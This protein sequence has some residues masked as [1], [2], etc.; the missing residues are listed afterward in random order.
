MAPADDLDDYTIMAISSLSPG[1]SPRL[2][3]EDPE[4]TR[5]L[6]ESDAEL[7]P[8][9]V[10][11]PTLRV[12]DG[13]HRLRAALLRGEEKIK[14]RFF[15]GDEEAAFV[16]AVESNIAHGL[17]LSLADR[18][19]AAARILS[20]HP[21]WSDRAIAAVTGL[22]AKTVDTIRRTA[23]AGIPQL[24]SRVGRDGRVRPLNSADGRRRACELF[25]LCPDAS[26]RKVAEQAGISLGTARDVRQRM[27]RGEDPIPAQQ[28]ARDERREQAPAEH[29]LRRVAAAGRVGGPK[30]P[31]TILHQ[32]QR[33]PSVRF[34]DSGRTLLRWLNE[35][36]TGVRGW[37][38]LSGTMPS[39]CAYMIADLACAMAEE[40][41]EFA[42]HVRHRAETTA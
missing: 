38:S 32:L 14:V 9:L 12:I 21:Q 13:M 35:H 4:H 24:H 30:D 11:R 20:S 15:D 42:E 26:L 41:L 1:E 16:T 25:T 6:A 19:A 36:M 39:H 3:G 37:E 7:P 34:T 17:P 2:S 33:D 40:W 5:L 29:R 10:H 28:R 23:T 27:L 22:S 18:E 31:A 8:I